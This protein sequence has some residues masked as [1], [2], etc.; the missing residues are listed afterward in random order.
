MKKEKIIDL[1]DWL[2]EEPQYSEW[3]ES[4][5][6]HRDVLKRFKKSKKKV[7]NEEEEVIFYEADKFYLRFKMHNSKIY[8]N[9]KADKLLVVEGNLLICLINSYTIDWESVMDIIPLL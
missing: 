4:K 8:Q 3:S 1:L 5:I 6:S 9:K 2:F 7:K